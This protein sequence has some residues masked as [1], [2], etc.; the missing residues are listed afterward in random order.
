MK[1][2]ILALFTILSLTS[3]GQTSGGYNNIACDPDWKPESYGIARIKIPIEGRVVSH[4][5]GALVMTTDYSYKPYL[6][7]AYHV[8]DL[9]EDGIVSNQEIAALSNATITFRDKQ[10]TCLGTENDSSV[11]YTGA[12]LVAAWEDTDFALLKLTEDLGPHPELFFLGWDKS[13]NTPDSAVCIFLPPFEKMKIAYEDNPLLSWKI[14]NNNYYYWRAEFAA[15]GLPEGASG[16]PVI[17]YDFNIVGT[18][19]G[20]RGENVS[21]QVAGKFSRSWT[22]GGSSATRLKTWLDP[23]NSGQTSINGMY[24]VPIKGGCNLFCNQETFTIY[25]PNNFP[26]S[27]GSIN[28]TGFSILTSSNLSINSYTNSLLTVQKITDGKGFIKVYY[29]GNVVATK[30]V[31]VGAPVVNDVYYMGGNIY[32][33]TDLESTPDPL[34]FYIVINGRRYRLL[35]G[36]GTI[37]LTNGTYNVEAYTSNQCGESDH[38]F[39]QIVVYGSGLYSLG[40]ISSDHQVTIETVDYSDSPQP[41]EAMQTMTTKRAAKDV[42]YELKN[43][44]TG[45]VSARGEMPAEGGVIDFSRVRSGLYVL[46]L[47]PAGREPETF[48]LSLK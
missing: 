3:L 23:T 28:S 1:K 47:S 13:G 34:Y 37:P 39:G 40:P 36:V 30:N 29:K 38:Y 16:A 7:T 42:P 43:A 35:G 5:N 4:G 45:E 20:N 15:S 6:L 22:G 12:S 31:W 41:L 19:K 32:I 11:V 18:L 26:V 21:Q 9:N 33:E 25:L 44:M 2:T 24:N 10:K 17:D 48:K 46:T 27:V 8:L 14:H